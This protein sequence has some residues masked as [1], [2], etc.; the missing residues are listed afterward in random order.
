MAVSARVRRGDLVALA[1]MS[2]GL[3]LYLGIID[4]QRT[5]YPFSG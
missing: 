1:G 2:I 5:R 4:Q 3:I